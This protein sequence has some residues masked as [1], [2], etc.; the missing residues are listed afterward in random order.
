MRNFSSYNRSAVRYALDSAA[1]LLLLLHVPSKRKGGRLGIR[2]T[3]IVDHAI[4]ATYFQLPLTQ[5]QQQQQHM[6]GACS[7]QLKLT[8]A[9][10]SASALTTAPVLA[11][12]DCNK[13]RF[14]LLSFKRS[15]G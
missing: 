6:D 1:A 3:A 11:M 5:Q 4:T 12:I 2:R 10:A 9:M 7:W 13:T 15:V 8:L 14:W